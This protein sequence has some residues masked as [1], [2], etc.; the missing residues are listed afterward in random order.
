MEDSTCNC[1]GNFEGTLYLSTNTSA[2]TISRIRYSQA[3]I[4]EREITAAL[5]YQDTNSSGLVTA[6]QF[7]KAMKQCHIELS[8]SDIQR[9]TLRFDGEDSQRIDIDK[10]M[11][12]IRG[13]SYHHDDD[14]GVRLSGSGAVVSRSKTLDGAETVAWTSLHKRVEELL[15]TGYTGREVFALFD[16]DGKGNLD[17]AAIQQGA[18]E[19]GTNLTRAEARGVLRRM[20]LLVGGA[21][22]RDTFF[23]AL[24]IDANADN[25]DRES[26]Q[27][28]RRNRRRDM[29]NEVDV[30]WI[31]V[32][33]VMTMIATCHAVMAGRPLVDR[34]RGPSKAL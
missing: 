6:K 9:L 11:K 8:E 29:D 28:S 5:Q 30:I 21:I 24:E 13:Q 19:A 12:F 26:R 1:S 22:N 4:H 34:P 3:K 31:G 7:N 2:L 16:P 18:R 23:D 10:F 15:D 17:V 27:E 14:Q 20:S 33:N 32:P 25:N